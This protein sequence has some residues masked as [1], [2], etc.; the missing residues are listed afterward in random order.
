M[1]VYVRSFKFVHKN[2]QIASRRYASILLNE[3]LISL[4][5]KTYSLWIFT[6][7]LILVLCMHVVH[8]CLYCH[9]HSCNTVVV[10]VA[11]VYSIA[12]NDMRVFVILV[13][14]VLPLPRC[15]IRIDSLGSE[16]S[17]ILALSLSECENVLHNVAVII[18]VAFAAA[19]LLLL[20]SVVCMVAVYVRV[21]TIQSM[22]YKVYKS[23]W[24]KS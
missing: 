23:V 24:F 7:A 13:V 16:F 6:V 17:P 11:A 19:A 15:L 5:K 12:Q 22:V 2:Y 21:H 1:Y 3:F 8:L 10:V 20:L 14:V 9:H 18:I 4:Y